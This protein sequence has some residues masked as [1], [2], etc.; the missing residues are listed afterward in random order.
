VFCLYPLV[1]ELL[2]IVTT[3]THIFCFVLPSR[4]LIPIFIAFHRIAYIAE[5]YSLI[6]AISELNME[7]L[8]KCQPRNTVVSGVCLVL[9][10]FY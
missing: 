5:T 10:V 4:R 2:T 1:A 7:V 3:L 9:R 8:C 6:L